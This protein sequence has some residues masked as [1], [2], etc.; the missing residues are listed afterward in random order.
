[1]LKPL[2]SKLESE[3]EIGNELLGFFWR[4]AG[5]V[6]PGIRRVILAASEDLYFADEGVSGELKGSRWLRKAEQADALVVQLLIALLPS[7]YLAA[8]SLKL[9]S[10]PKVHVVVDVKV[11][12]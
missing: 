3:I 4:F 10:H 12:S 8:V 6:S 9:S 1:M 11:P 5:R 2:V 7:Q